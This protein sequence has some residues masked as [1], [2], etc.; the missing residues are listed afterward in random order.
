M[1]KADK[2]PDSKITPKLEKVAELLK[3]RFYAYQYIHAV[4]LKYII[5]NL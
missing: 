4:S 3:D 2:V 5:F 1:T